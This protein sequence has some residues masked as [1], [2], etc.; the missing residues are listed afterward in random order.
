MRE[1]RNILKPFSIIGL[2]FLD[3]NGELSKKTYEYLMSEELSN[4]FRSTYANSIGDYSY[5]IL[6]EN[7]YNY[8]NS[9]V[10]VHYWH[11]AKY[12]YYPELL[13]LKNIYEAMPVKTKNRCYDGSTPFS[14]KEKNMTFTNSATTALSSVAETAKRANDSF[15]TLSTAL[16]YKYS[17]GIGTTHNTIDT[18]STSTTPMIHFDST[19]ITISNDAELN[20]NYEKVY[21]RLEKVKEERNRK[22]SKKMFE[23]VMKNFKFGKCGDNVKMSVYGPA[24][25]DY[26]GNYI[27]FN[28]DEAMDVT[29]MT[30]DFDCFYKMPVAQD[31]VEI[32]DYVYHLDDPVKVV[33]V[34]ERGSLVCV[35]LFTHEEVTVVPVKNVFGFNFFTKLVN[36]G[37]GLFGANTIDKSNPFGS[38]LPFFLMSKG[39]GNDNLM[40]AM[41]MSQGKTDFNSNPLMLMALMGDKN[42]DM[43]PVLMMMQMGQKPHECRCGG[44]HEEKR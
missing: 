34:T 6:N 38:M 19:G 32:G 36:F 5:L 35:R 22:E 42:S 28:G 31:D 4:K 27:A 8:R 11:K 17:T 15:D 24:F 18:Y 3:K 16:N 14:E 43:L 37:E 33:D 1:R 23:K 7:A 12:E 10:V 21:D 41:M 29:G 40:M 39:G 20:L 2:K 44:C 30:F 25:K 13:Y 26:D 9:R